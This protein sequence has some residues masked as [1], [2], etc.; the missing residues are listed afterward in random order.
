MT[1]AE[2]TAQ[3]TG[4]MNR[5]DMTAALT[6]TFIT[7]A[8]LR[9]QRE[10]RAPFQE[11][12]IVYTIPESYVATTGLAIPNDLLELIGLFAGADQEVQL[13]RCQLNHAKA[14]A[15]SGS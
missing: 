15:A 13:Q 11:A 1:L 14:L 7:Q 5:R 2:L 6:T 9:I 4:L 12:T 3:F 8:I 10:L